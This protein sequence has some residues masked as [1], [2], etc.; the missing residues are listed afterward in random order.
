MHTSFLAVALA[1][2]VSGAAAPQGA[3]TSVTVNAPAGQTEVVVTLRGTNPCGAA[4]IDYGDGTKIT[5]ALVALPST[6]AHQYTKPGV[7]QVTAGGNG[8]CGGEVGTS[9]TVQPSHVRAPQVRNEPAPAARPLAA[10]DSIDL[11]G[12]GSV[13]LT[14]WK[15]TDEVFRA[16]DFNGDSTLSRTEVEDGAVDVFA[17]LDLNDDRRIAPNEWR[18]ARQS[19]DTHDRN[20][21]GFVTANEFGVTPGALG[22]GGRRGI[23]GARRGGRG[24]GGFGAGGDGGSV[25]VRGTEAWTDTGI[26]VKAGQSLLFTASGTIRMSTN[27]DDTA[28]PRGARSGRQAA[29]MP[30]PDAVAGSLI[31]R[32][33]NS[34]PFLIGDQ[35]GPVRMPATGRLY[36]GIND[37]H[38]DD[39]AGMFRVTVE[40]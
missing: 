38:F 34:R 12:N 3:V 1:A 25:V 4:T 19:F 28:T 18:T 2:V 15:G 6:H 36:L 29:N 31:A 21:D 11:D 16:M 27:P 37:D 40:R 5:H 35:T 39:N 13:A 32:V 20:G 24:D 17:S 8:N 7:Y 22:R 26:N 33:G 23:A 14:E 30:V 9:I 10:L